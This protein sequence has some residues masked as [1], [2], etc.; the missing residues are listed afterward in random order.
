M[1]EQ[2]LTP[3]HK[4]DLGKPCWDC[5]HYCGNPYSPWYGRCFNLE[6]RSHHGTH[7]PVHIDFARG[8]RRVC[9]RSGSL[10]EPRKDPERK[11]LWKRIFG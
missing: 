1:S 2:E 8:E 4:L 5:K 11:S 7:D 3:D 10:F 9:G 6:V